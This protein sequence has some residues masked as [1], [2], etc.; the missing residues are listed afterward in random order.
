MTMGWVIA[1]MGLGLVIIGLVTENHDKIWNF[2]GSKIDNIINFWWSKKIL[3]N[4]DKIEWLSVYCQ[5]KLDDYFLEIDFHGLGYDSIIIS[6]S[7]KTKQIISVKNK[8]I[9]KYFNNYMKMNDEE[10]QSFIVNQK[11]YKVL[12]NTL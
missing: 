6:K 3:N 8:E 7:K 10:R 12:L 9:R 1:L 4:L 2:F 11:R 5:F